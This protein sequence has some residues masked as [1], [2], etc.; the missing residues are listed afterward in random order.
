MVTF[1]R[2][3]KLNLLWDIEFSKESWVR[4]IFYISQFIESHTATKVPSPII[5]MTK[6]TALCHQMDSL[7]K[8]S[9][10]VSS[11]GQTDSWVVYMPTWTV[12]VQEIKPLGD[13]LAR[14]LQGCARPQSFDNSSQ[15][16][17]EGEPVLVSQP[18]WY[19]S[20][21]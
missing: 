2:I 14:L 18:N 20:G 9:T 15:V 13:S 21:T 12:P 1:L 11:G 6:R 17:G 4:V 7:C 10:R 8:Q 3:S 19:K 16:A 5:S